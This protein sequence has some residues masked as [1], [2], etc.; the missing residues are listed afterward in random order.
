MK[1]L[2]I[3]PAPPASEYPRGPFR[4]LWVPTGVGYLG[5][6]LRAAGHD[7]RIHLVTQVI[8]EVDNDRTKTDAMLRQ[9]VQEHQPE[10]V[11]L[12]VTTPGMTALQG[13][14]DIVRE[15]RGDGALIIAGGP[16][17]TALPERTLNE[18]P[19]LD[20]VAMGEGE[21]TI[22]EIAQRGLAADINGLVYR[23][24][25]G[26]VHTPPRSHCTDLDSLAPMDY[27]MF[28]MDYFTRRSRW[29][30]R[31]LPLRATN[32]RISRGCS[33]RC[34]F[35]GGHLI[36]GLGV[37]Y[38]SIDWVIDQM[39]MVA[40]RFGVEA[41]HFEDDTIGADRERLFELCDA[42]QRRGLQKRL[43]W[44]ACL[45]VDQADREV[46]DRLR[47]A[48]CIQIEYGFESGSDTELKRLGKGATA[49]LNEQASRLTRE[50]GLRILANIMVGSPGETPEDVRRTIQFLKRTTPEVVSASLLMPLPGTAIYDAL[51]EEVRQSLD[52]GSYTFA[53]WP[54]QHINLTAMTDREYSREVRRFF[55]YFSQPWVIRQ[56][57]SDTPE[58]DTTWRKEL[59]RERRRFARR[60]PLKAWRL[61]I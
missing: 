4:S 41:I 37:R 34:R 46:L 25:E 13:I 22:V 44:D 20:G 14:C 57:L 35:C 50:A 31:W 61:P 56:L 45:R 33:H 32:L 19:G 3:Y 30:I 23:D 52:W 39:E 36:G 11:G 48:G 59:I 43:K 1:A 24:G 55:K 5:A 15:I 9:L 54:G 51:P 49:D 12:S 27:D 60:H 16:H 47:Q 28:D 53:Y 18:V 2:L 40:D 6:A 17:P 29:L 26:F 10:L 42:I 21:E 8:D 38:H 7:V 58:D